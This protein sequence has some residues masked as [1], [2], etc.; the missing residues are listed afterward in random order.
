[1]PSYKQTARLMQFASALGAD[2]LL[3][4]SL[5]GTEALSRLFDYQ[6]ELFAAAGT[7]IDAAS[8]VG[9]KVTV[10][11]N[12]LDV[13]ETRYINGLVAAFEQ[14]S[15]DEEFDVYRAHLVPSLWQ[16][17]LSSNCRVFQ[18]MTV[19]EIIKAVISPYGLS[20]NDTTQG[21][22]QQLDYCT[23]Y[24]E[25]DFQFISRLAEQFG[26]F[27]WFEHKNGDNTVA[28]GD[29][30]KSYSPCPQVATVQYSPQ[31]DDEEG[32]YHSIVHDLRAT[33]SMVTG[34]F[35][36]RD[37]DFR[38]YAPH[39]VGPVDSTEPTGKN[40]LE[41]FHFPAGEAGYVKESTK[42]HTTP[43][44]A[45]LMLTAQRDAGDLPA[46]IFRG[47]SNA[48]SFLPG[49]T[50]TVTKH[51]NESWNQSYL[52]TEVA[53]QVMQSPSYRSGAEDKARPYRNRFTAIESERLFRPP[54]RT[55]KP[56]IH[57][58]QTAVVVAPAGED[59]YIDKLG[60]VCVQFFWDRERKP[61]TVDNTW[62]R[63]AQPWA[64]N[65]WG[66]YFWPRVKDEVVVAFLNGDPDDPVVVGSVYNGVNV[67]KYQLPDMST[68]TGLVTRSSKGGS[69]ANANE[70]RFEDKT[71]SEQIF[72]NAEKDMD[73]RI[74]NDS[75]RFVGGKD[76]V[77]VT[78]NQLEEID[79]DRHG[80]VKGKTVDKVGTDAD[81]DI[82]QN[83]NEKIGQNYSL[84]VGQNHG[85]KVGMNYAL[86]AGMEVYIKA[87]MTLVIESGMELCLKGPGGFITIG[88]AGV[89]ISGTMVMIN[90]GGAAVSGSPAQLQDPGAPTAP[91]K[92]D[93][94]TKGGKL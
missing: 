20:L 72:L 32:L 75:R 40:A 66:T 34:K 3:I 92:A 7:A 67:P 23:Q 60:R 76:S 85:E 11:L 73:H 51:R 91:D 6:V 37:Y 4:E 89:A 31:E 21:K 82:G 84:K 65:G 93:D 22:Y 49:F 77:F 80:N 26:I 63:V 78:A 29:D 12:L 86:D 13:Q 15:G 53:H 45:T 58:P 42:E 47:V 2:V 55:P 94:G 1:M 19:M 87:G 52:L 10:A 90:S 83:R 33:A 62:V 69:A 36:S 17:T 79:G 68:R 46:A 61:N 44:F 48:R 43:D 59:M 57:G 16:L 81:I 88:P 30:R 39:V 64:G 41:Q 38:T 70:L 18:N 74:E 50:F 5:E 8:I 25:S 71:G 28:F 35:A 56:R 9:T 27:Y 54:M 14:T 24:D